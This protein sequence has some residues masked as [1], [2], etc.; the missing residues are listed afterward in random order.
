MQKTHKSVINLATRGNTRA[1]YLH[2]SAYGKAQNG[3]RMG[4]AAAPQSFASRQKL[5]AHRNFV[6]KY[7]DSKITRR[8]IS[9]DASTMDV[10]KERYYK[11]LMSD[12]SY[13]LKREQAIIE[14]VAQRKKIAERKAAEKS[15]AAAEKS[16]KEQLIA[17]SAKR[18]HEQYQQEQA[19]IAAA[20]EKQL[21]EAALRKQ[22]EKDRA[23][24]QIAERKAAREAALEAERQ[25][26]AAKKQAA[27][28]AKKQAEALQAAKTATAEAK[29]NLHH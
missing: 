23:T 9:Q 7:G 17:A 12:K 22:A 26:A 4:V 19:K 3:S 16:T 13:G 27:L 2:S 21:Q 10:S 25:S 11:S 29:S 1:D 14:A 18:Q 8:A 15:R 28:E 5:D 6:P 20:K 24:A